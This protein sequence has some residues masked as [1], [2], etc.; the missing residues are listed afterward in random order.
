MSARLEA[1]REGSRLLRSGEY[2]RAL[3]AMEA[4][5]KEHGSHV[6]LRADLAF[7]AYLAG[8]MGAFRLHT[9]GLEAEFRRAEARLGEKS[10][11]LTLVS[12]AK[13]CEELARVADAAEYI[14]RA[15]SVLG[16]GHPQDFHVRCQRLR[17]LASFGREDEA[18]PLYR[19]CL[20]V[21]ERNPHHLIECYHALL[22]TEARLLGWGAA[23][24]RLES[25]AKR[26]DLRSADLRMTVMDLFEIALEKGDAAAQSTAREFFRRHPGEAPDAF[27]AELLRLSE[28][29]ASEADFLRW[30]RAVS[31]MGQLRL[32]ALEA[33]RPGADGQPA[34]A[35]LAFLLES[36]DHR[37]R[38]LLQRK[39]RAVFAGGEE[40]TF[41]INEARRE[42][43]CN[44]KTISF[45]PRAQPWELLRAF[46][47]TGEFAP[48]ALLKAL[49]KRDSESELESLRI[50]L[51]RLNKK[52][53][54]LAGLDWVL[55]FGKLKVQRHHR[56]RFRT[57]CT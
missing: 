26:E 30:T 56:A 33:A 55:R 29:P 14:E 9:E 40:Q 15:L 19:D 41:E 42:I 44:G 1:H 48:G 38:Q 37:S 18:A 6:G 34:R 31:P 50:A 35:R 17:L 57:N 3:E 49:G 47:E 22:L 2:A 10:R 43:R 32:L 11:L 4:S 25:L 54:P 28:A 8:D 36:L 39:W 16:P 51:L 53:A 52:L 5:L 7:T 12:L 27:E 23:W 13:L 45:G 46:A 21:S 20:G 24:A